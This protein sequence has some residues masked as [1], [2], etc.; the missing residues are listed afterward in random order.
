M[1]IRITASLVIYNSSPEIFIPAV[2]SY[3][4]STSKS[5]LVLVDNSVA[6]MIHPI[7]KNQRVRYIF[8]N[9]NLGFG[10]AH[11]LAFSAVSDVSDFHLIFNP[12]VTFDKEVILRIVDVMQNNPDIGAIM[13]KIRY[14]DGSLQRLCKLLPTPVDLIFR[15]FIPSKTIR[16]KINRRYEMYDLAQDRLSNVPVI[17]GCFLL[18]RSGVFQKI[19]GF[20]N[21]YFM[22]L[23]DVDLVR[24]IGDSQRVVYDPSVSVT[25]AYAKGSYNNKKLLLYHAISAI[26]YFTKWGWIFDS[27]RKNRN[28]LM[29]KNLGW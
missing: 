1:T 23:E 2:N 13:P 6:P 29:A 12:D 3:L 25:H 9:K 22:Y 5:I 7:I 18:V 16:N 28:K 14:P 26:K 4:A 27:T 8:N 10:V 15:R 21:R 20:D 17:S 19:K 24:R 11:N